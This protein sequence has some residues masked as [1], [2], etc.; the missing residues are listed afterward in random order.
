MV[1]SKLCSQISNGVEF[2]D[3]DKRSSLLRYGNNYDR[4]S[5]IVQALDEAPSLVMLKVIKK[6][7]TL[8]MFQ[9]LLS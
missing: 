9:T 1:G 2:I 4:K 6:T 5:V 3:G 8:S 7:A